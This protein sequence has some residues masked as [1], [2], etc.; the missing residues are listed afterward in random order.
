MSDISGI[1]DNG[2]ISPVCKIKE[3][4][5]AWTELK[6]QPFRVE[7]T[8]GIPRSRPFVV[9]MVQLAGAGNIP[10]NGA[11]NQQL[12]AILRPAA[13]ELLHLR[14]EPLDDVEGLLWEQSAMTRFNPKGARARV[15]MFSSAMDP[16][17]ASTTFFVMGGLGDKDMNLEVRNPNA[18]ALPMARFAFWGVRYVLDTLPSV[19]A[20]AVYLPAEGRQN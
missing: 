8:E 10:A 13:K 1:Y 19:P 18:I 11:I 16:Y 14:F 6:W 4:I 15:S 12:L 9:D 5:C 2:P 20:N 17:L 3:N 7:F